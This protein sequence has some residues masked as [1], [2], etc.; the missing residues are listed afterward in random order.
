MD[1]IGEER[2]NNFGSLMR[3]IN[4]RSSKDIDVYFPEYG[5]VCKH[6]RYDNF[7]RGK[8]KCPYE[9]RYHDHGYLGEGVY[10]IKENGELTKCYRTWY[11]ML[12]R[13]YG[14]LSVF[15]TPTYK[16]CYVCDEWLNYQKFA[17]WFENNYYQINDDVMELDKDI[18]YKGNKIY[19]PDTCVFVNSKINTLF[20]KSDTI[21]GGL[22]IGV[23][24]DKR[25]EN[26]FYARCNNGEGKRIFIKSCSS[27][28]EAFNE[29]KKFKEQ[30]IKNI[31]E[32]YKEQIPLKLYNALINYK[33][34]I[35]D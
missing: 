26:V 32:E 27:I 28:E 35:N 15:K 21:R 33:V 31:A 5:W 23:T 22:P 7:T 24:V 25:R 6:I 1:R 13:C 30:L 34:D 11:H 16:D 8:V 3:I 19:S 18:L 14:Q 20:V 9:P 29:Y 10:E 2:Y 17:Y 12:E 4:Y